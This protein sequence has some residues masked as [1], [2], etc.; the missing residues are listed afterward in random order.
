MRIEGILRFL[1]ALACLLA[2][3]SSA[4]SQ[5]Q[6]P[7]PALVGQITSDRE[8]TMEGVVERQEAMVDDHH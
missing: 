6:H 3:T 7:P 2:S 1:A 4:P 5:A 8:G